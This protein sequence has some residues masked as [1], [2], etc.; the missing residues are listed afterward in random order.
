MY[1]NY[2]RQLN[3]LRIQLNASCNFKCFFCHMEGTESNGHFLSP[4]EI[5]DVV[6]IA[7]RNGVNRI[8][9]TGGEPLL[10]K[11]LEEIISRVRKHIPGDISLTTNGFF[12]K[13]RAAGLK[14]AGLNRINISLHSI[15]ESEFMRITD[16]DA[17]DRVKD[18]I[19][20][21]MKA[22]LSPIKINFVVL[23]GINTDQIDQM[24]DF[25]SRRGLILQ[26]IEYETDR[27]GESDENFRKYHYDLRKIEDSLRDRVFDTEYNSLHNRERYHIRVNGGSTAVIEFVR[28]QRNSDFCD[29]CTRLRVTSRGEFQTCL[30][31]SDQLFSFKGK[32]NEEILDSYKEAVMARVPYWREADES[33]Y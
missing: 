3:S 17:L 27:K 12:L 28:P 6:A 25:T 21:A 14:K 15:K 5:E 16:V 11:D 1:D 23:K 9:F 19:E 33:S 10:R 20:D 4:S 8:K 24:I 13:D 31:R 32:T 26:L 30:N 2:G 18:A 22:G 7:S 29:H